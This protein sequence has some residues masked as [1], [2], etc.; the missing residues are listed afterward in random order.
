MANKQFLSRKKY[1]SV[2]IKLLAAM[3]VMAFFV[4]ILIL[5]FF[6]YIHGPQLLS[7]PNLQAKQARIHTILLYTLLILVFI[8]F[9]G[10]Y[11]FIRDVL[12]P[13]K[14][15]RQ[16]VEKMGEGNLDVQVA[17]HRNDEFARLT[18]A[19]NDM[20]R[21]IREMVKARD[22]LLI[23]VSHELRSP[24]TRIKVALEFIPASEKKQK[25]HD[26]LSEM[27]TMITEILETERL[28]N[29]HGKLDLKLHNM[30][31]LLTEVK[32]SF[33]QRPPGIEMADIP[34][35]VY[36]QIDKERIKV[37]LQNLLENAL[38]YSLPGSKPVE[39]LLEE[40]EDK[41]ILRITD[42]GIG[43]PEEE[44][45][46]LYEPFYR[47]DRSRSKKTGGYGLGLSMCKR[48]MESHQGDIMTVNNPVRGV[49]VLLTFK[50]LEIGTH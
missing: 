43:I 22:Q 7:L 9:V 31:G 29:G 8:T 35:E 17:V 47:V 24:I 46:Y 27:E 2:F 50:R 19:F 40:Q 49:T 6:S 3:V 21:R 1:R 13:L 37:V 4:L 30:S 10:A 12:K 33:G 39:V 16:G 48:I 38:K 26:D 34:A 23:D 14:G 44:L 25:I 11:F 15:L 41:V 5:T 42:D 18:E 20:A 28:K 45:P 32:D 36:L